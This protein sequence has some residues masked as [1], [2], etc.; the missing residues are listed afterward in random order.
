MV[1]AVRAR[2]RFAESGGANHSLGAIPD[3]ATQ[4]MTSYPAN[5]RSNQ[6]GSNDFE[7]R[8]Q[9]L[10]VGPVDLHAAHGNGVELVRVRQHL[11]DT[12]PSGDRFVR[13]CLRPQP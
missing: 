6:M 7:M 3:A 13:E 1:R 2:A 4:P 8:R 5:C 11:D 10:A 12:R 9:G